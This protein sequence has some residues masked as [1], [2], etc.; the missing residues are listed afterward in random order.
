MRTITDSAYNQ[1]PESLERPYSASVPLSV[2]R[3]LAAELQMAQAAIHQLNQQNEYLAQENH[4]L[5]QEIAKTVNAV[6]HLQNA[7]NSSSSSTE[8][9]YTNAPTETFHQTSTKTRKKQY[10]PQNRH[11]RHHEAPQKQVKR[12]R[13][14]QVAPDVTEFVEPLPE[15]VFIEE[16]QVSYYYDD[17]SEMSQVSGWW[18]IFA[19]VFIIVM[20]FGAGYLVV[21]PLLENHT[22]SQ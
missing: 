22:S 11:Y 2:Y 9:V 4:V 7:V 16:E 1:S 12:S 17:E 5:R 21:R 10:A 8:A 6:L 15:P 20:G 18:L 14:S 19:I 3:E 13:T